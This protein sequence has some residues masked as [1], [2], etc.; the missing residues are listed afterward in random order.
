MSKYISPYALNVIGNANPITYRDY[1]QNAEFVKDI[2]DSSAEV[3]YTISEKS[4]EMIATNTQLQERGFALL[5]SIDDTLKD[6]F[7]M[8]GYKLDDVSDEV[9]GLGAKLDW[10][11]SQMIS[12]IGR[13]NDTLTELLAIAKTPAQTWAYNQ[14]EIGRD[15]MRQELY[16]EALE[17]ISRAANGFG[18]QTGYKLEYR[19]HYNL[20]ILYLGSVKNTDPTI[21]DLAKAEQAFLLSA[22]YAKADFPLEASVSF[23]AA[24]WAAY[25]QGKMKEAENYTQ[26]ALQ[27]DSKNCEAFFKLA[28]IQMHTDRPDVAISNLRKAIE[29]D[30]NY[31]V[32]ASQTDADFLKYES[33]VQALFAEMKKQLANRV[34]T[35]LAETEKSI[36]YMHNW[37][38]EENFPWETHSAEDFFRD[39]KA[40]SETKTYFGYLKALELVKN[41]EA[42]AYAAKDA[43][44]K[45][46][47]ILA[48]QA[49]EQTKQTRSRISGNNIPISSREKWEEAERLFYPAQQFSIELKSYEHYQN[50]IQGLSKIRSLYLDVEEN[51]KRGIQNIKSDAEKRRKTLGGILYGSCGFVIGVIVGLILALPVYLIGSLFDNIFEGFRDATASNYP[52]GH[53]ACTIVFFISIISGS[54]IGARIGISQFG[55]SQ[56]K[57]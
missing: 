39:A 54:T 27:I 2:T 45:K 32:I 16:A 49:L 3:Q 47:A 11:F 36:K 24:G 55:N 19:F 4:R 5:E 25:C 53:G 33:E 56:R 31:M 57:K 7:E 13:V 43:Q 23:T 34:E 12:E 22:R 8:V 21:L 48:E 1:L 51:V 6:G 10:G 44:K 37:H 35:A 41:A 9:R 40:Q 46:L 17:S 26:Q 42:A 28:K 38:T 20:G 15:A 14:F 50:Q 29:L 18:D 30:S 52:I